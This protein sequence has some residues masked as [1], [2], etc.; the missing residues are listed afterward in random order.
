M[1][2]ETLSTFFALLSLACVAGTLATIALCLAAR[3]ADAGSAL[4]EARAIVGGAGLW[5]AWMVAA[6]ATAGSLYYSLGAG[7][8]PCE[9]CWYQRVCIY[10]LAIALLVAAL[11]RDRKVWLTAVPL[12]GVGVVIAAFTPCCR[13]SR[14]RRRSAA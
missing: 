12:A 1:T 14:T 13:R 4:G 10:P 7:Y 2:V 11:R 6:T 9:L 8:E 3:R 5:L